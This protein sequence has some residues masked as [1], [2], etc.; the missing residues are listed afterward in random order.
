MIGGACG[1]MV[2][3]MAIQVQILYEVV[4]ISHSANT[5]RKGRHPT[6]LSPSIN[7]RADWDL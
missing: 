5:L 4:C 2:M 7:G 6:I 3:D 1:I